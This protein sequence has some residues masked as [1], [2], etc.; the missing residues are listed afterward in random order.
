MRP[1]HYWLRLAT[2]CVLV[3]S[4]AC[5]TELMTAAAMQSEFGGHSISGYYTRDQVAFVEIYLSAGGI[6]YK[7][8]QG[9]D[10]GTWSLRGA[11]F[12]TFYDHMNGACWYVVKE[13]P[14]C[15]EFYDAADFPGDPPAI[16]E[17]VKHTIRARAARDG[18]KLTCE[19]W[20]GS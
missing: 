10:T 20:V 12:C 11:T 2:A 3:G 4:P 8:T 9:A 13:K 19:P 1:V 14:D 7:D 15:Y 17:M 6:D 5:A 18:G 16:E